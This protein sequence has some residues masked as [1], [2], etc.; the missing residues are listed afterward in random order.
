[1]A[2]SKD[3]I[4]EEIPLG[5][6]KLR[7]FVRFP[8]QLHRKDLE[9][10]RTPYELK[11]ELEELFIGTDDRKSTIIKHQL[12]TDWIISNFFI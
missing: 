6:P 2:H 10:A 5:H 7:D 1:M 4:V 8:W 9:F 12:R 11:S 3:L